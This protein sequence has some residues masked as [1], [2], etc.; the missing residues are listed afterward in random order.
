[1][2]LNQREGIEKQR[3][4]FW[5]LLGVILVLLLLPLPSASGGELTYIDKFIH[6]LIFS[7]LSIVALRVWASNHGKVSVLLI[8]FG[9]L[10]ELIQGLTGWRSAS[11]GDFTANALGVFLGWL[12]LNFFLRKSLN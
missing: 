8:A 3:L 11:W 1:M 5:L 9:G 12:L 2:T 4:L 6:L 10:T 7:G